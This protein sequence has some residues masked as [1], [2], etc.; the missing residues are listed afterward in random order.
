[1][2]IIELEENI[3]LPTHIAFEFI[4]RNIF[5]VFDKE[6]EAVE[7]YAE[8]HKIFDQNPIIIRINKTDNTIQVY[9]SNND[10]VLIIDSLAEIEPYTLSNL[11][12]KDYREWRPHLYCAPK[13][14]NYD[15]ID[16]NIVFRDQQYSKLNIV[17]YEVS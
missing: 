2:S 10:T 3:I 14:G 17:R 16:R 13:N 6:Y 11:L 5:L 1:M 4:S 15:P 8:L 9:L 12:K 7:Y